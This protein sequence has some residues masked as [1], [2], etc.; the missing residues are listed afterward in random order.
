[1]DKP[2]F[3]PGGS[4]RPSCSIAGQ[5]SVRWEV[6]M[7]YLLAFLAGTILG[8]I[9]GALVYRKNAERAEAA[10]KDTLEEYLKLKKR[11]G[12]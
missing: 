2:P 9:L 12:G 1:M 8:F 3:I 11:V 4:G 7:Y 6:D 5:N 10:L